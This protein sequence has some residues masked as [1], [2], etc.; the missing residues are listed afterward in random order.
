MTRSRPASS[1]SIN[2]SKMINTNMK[3]KKDLDS[4]ER[5]MIEG[6]IFIEISRRRRGLSRRNMREKTQKG[7]DS[8]KKSMKES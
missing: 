6:L 8:R 4:K 5:R 7:L 2:L 1:K 3:R